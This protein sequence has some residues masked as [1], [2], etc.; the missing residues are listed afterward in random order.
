MFGK[1]DE[2][3]KKKISVQSE[4]MGHVC[5]DSISSFTI[6]LLD[7]KC[8]QMMSCPTPPMKSKNHNFLFLVKGEVLVGINKMRH[9]VLANECITIPAETTFSIIYFKNCFGYMGGFHSDF[10]CTNVLISNNLSGFA[11]LQS[12]C[13]IVTCFDH[14]RSGFI[15]ILLERIYDETLAVPRNNDV[16]RANLNSFLVEIAAENEKTSVKPLISNNV[17][18]RFMNLIFGYDKRKLSISEYA[19]KLNVSSGYLNKIIKL[20]TGKSA[21][22]WIE[23]SLMLSAKMMLSNTDLPISDLASELGFLDQSYFTRR[24]KLHE[25]MSPTDYRKAVRKKR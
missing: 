21:S 9:L 19:D 25:K 12:H 13:G 20:N 4:K 15:Q 18:N 6:R 24:F 8:H 17:C 7:E 11:F 1:M 10:L 22:D 14:S 2:A 23:D 16:I 5:D 3:S